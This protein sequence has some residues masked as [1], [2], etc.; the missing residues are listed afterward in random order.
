MTSIKRQY[1][2]N[3]FDPSINSN[4][5]WIGVAFDDGTLET[6][7]GRVRDG[8]NLA[9]TRKNLGSA[10][11]AEQELERKRQ[12]K[13]RK[14]YLDTS[15]F[16][17]QLEKT[18]SSRAPLDLTK[19]A[20]EQIS[21]A[22]ED[23]TTAEFIKYLAEVNI[24]HITQTTSVKYN[25]ANATFSTP[26]GVLTPEAISR[27]R[28]MLNNIRRLN[29]S[30]DLSAAPR[31]SFVRNY[32]QLVPKDFGMKI[33]P[34]ENLLSTKKQLDTESSILE[35]LEASIANCAPETETGKVFECS[36]KKVPHWTE[37]GRDVFRKIRAIYEK[38]R[39]TAHHPATASLKLARI[40]EVEIPTMKSRF[41]TAAEKLG[42]V[43]D[44]LWHG[45]RASNLLSILRQGL[46]IPPANAA[47]CT[48]RMFGNGIYTSLQST[49]ALNYATDFW[50]RSGGQKQR[51]FMFLCT[52]A[53][54][55]VHKPRSSG[56]NF[57]VSNSDSTWVEPGSAGVMNHE[58][59]VYDLA[60]INLR[61][62]CEFSPAA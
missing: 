20:C 57:P 12:E 9:S 18:D 21:G 10:Y 55:R 37:E 50:N 45:T 46:I 49:K 11:F 51:T 30:K 23:S 47:Q 28:D 59:I 27:A 29:D 35:A 36:L 54:G 42:N 2:M 48:G 33:P 6:R 53:L 32:F 34:I 22:T 60:Q 40:Y 7:Y 24:H 13:L 14:G 61:Y 26:L 39:N 31:A 19:I 15:V 41:E 56:A 1:R 3:K 4:K 52:V 25:A 62:L 43:R 38:T 44:D 8:A 16:E 17:G 5:V 58:A